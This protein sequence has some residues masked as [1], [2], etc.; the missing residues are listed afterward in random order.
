MV[1]YRYKK[2]I[3]GY[4]RLVTVYTDWAFIRGLI[5]QGGFEAEISGGYSATSEIS[6]VDAVN[7]CIKKIKGD[8]IK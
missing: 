3:C 8:L 7:K 1:F 4:D 6:D 5:S 2:M